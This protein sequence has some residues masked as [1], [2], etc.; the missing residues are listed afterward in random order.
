MRKKKWW[1]LIP[2]VLVLVYLAGPQPG[3]SDFDTQLP[4]VPA[5]PASLSQYIRVKESK[6]KIRPD[7]EARIV[8]AS[9]TAKQKN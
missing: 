3:S 2:L 8:W 1:I 9:D 7:N 4:S 6:H 5:D